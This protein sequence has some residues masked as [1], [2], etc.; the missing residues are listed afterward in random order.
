M[1][2]QRGCTSI[3]EFGGA[4]PQEPARPMR[5]AF[6]KALHGVLHST[7]EG[8]RTMRVRRLESHAN[9][10]RARRGFAGLRLPCAGLL[11]LMLSGAMAHAGARLSEVRT[12]QV[13]SMGDGSD[14][15]ALRARIVDR[16]EKSGRLRVVEDA[17]AADVI[18]R[19]TSGIWATGTVSL[20]PRS[21]AAAET[22]YQGY[23]SLELVDR[24]NHTL[25]S[26]LVTPSRFRTAN[27]TDDLAEHAVA[28]LLDALSSGAAGAPSSSATGASAQA[29]L[30][31][32]GS[33]LAAPLY[34][35]WFQSSGIPVTYDAIGSEAG[36]EQLAAQ[37]VDFAAS[38]MP[39][40][41]QESFAA[42][43]ATQFPTV[44]GG[45]VPIYNLPG[46]GRALRFTPQLLAGIYAGAIRKWN[47]PRILEVNRGAHLPDAEIA[48]V[49]RSDGSG[50]TFVWTS[51][52][53]LASPQWK[54]SAGAGARVDWPVGA[55]AEGS[56]GVAALVAKTPNSIG[57]VELI[58]AIQHELNYAAVENP[59]GEFIKADL[60]SI[61]AAASG[62]N[63]DS[64]SRFSI[65]NAPGRDAYPISTFTFLLVPGQGLSPEKR[66][67]IGALLHWMLTAGQKEC[68]SLGYAPLPHAMVQRELAAADAMK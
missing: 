53:S 61:T 56:N 1:Y 33:T 62:A 15:A 38:D 13:G 8:R 21:K 68:A 18:L 10:G 58:Y 57:Y 63:F 50:T 43:H 34:L 5:Y 9:T 19:G 23:L 7:L 4:R 14:A 45:V 52:L 37:K 65:L 27:I 64:G 35:K 30:H 6:I 48:V 3:F 22:I 20:H 25:W 28:H 12:I 17:S 2:P 67:A 41:A 32:S 31:A 44:A 54:S 55:G 51:F 39:L 29:A 60:A 40:N 26:Y 24:S 42:L 47:D 36:I 11:L 59:A 49:H 66:A 46:Q 16:L